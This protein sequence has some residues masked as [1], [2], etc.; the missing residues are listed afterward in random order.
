MEPSDLAHDDDD[1]L[2]PLAQQEIGREYHGASLLDALDAL[3]GPVDRH[4]VHH[5]A[6][7]RQL[8]LN[9][10]PAG[11]SITLRNGDLIELYLEPA[12]LSRQVD[13]RI[14]WLHRED[15]FGVAAKPT[16]LPFDASRG[17]S[18]HSTIEH[19][20]AGSPSGARP[21][22]LHRLDK[23]TSGVVVVAFDNKTE[24]ELAA[25]LADGTAWIEYMVVLRWPPAED[26]GCIDLPLAH[27]RRSDQGLHADPEHGR[28]ARTHWKVAERWGSFALMR[29][30]PE[31]GRSHQVRAHLAAFGHPILGDA[32]YGEDGVI[33]LSQLKL[34][35]R[36]KRRKPERPL[37]E[38]PA[39]HAERFVHEGLGLD[40]RA[41]VPHDLEVL[42][43]QLKRLHERGNIA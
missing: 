23:E 43:R 27:G 31:A 13:T 16:G 7:N 5:A 15:H 38:R 4:R 41:P 30:R 17:R 3:W 36:P 37:L 42:I 32:R 21:R 8:H 10:E 2:P 11:P 20:Q 1:P 39:L 12:E 26:E 6:R 28:Q 22:P 19:L 33:M 18:G 34:D 9:G 40:L 14:P 29:V 24:R 25:A 35:Y